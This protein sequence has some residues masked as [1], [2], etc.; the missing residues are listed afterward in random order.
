MSSAGCHP[1]EEEEEDVDAD[2][3]RLLSHGVHLSTITSSSSS[4]AIGN[5]GQDSLFSDSEGE[6]AEVTGL[7]AG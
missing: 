6:E 5:V 4:S 2:L 7:L 1:D 3:S